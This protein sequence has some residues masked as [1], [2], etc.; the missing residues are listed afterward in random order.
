M[1]I[2]ETSSGPFSA[3]QHAVASLLVI[4]TNLDTTNLDTHRVTT[5]LDTHRIGAR[6]GKRINHA[7]LVLNRCLSRVTGP[8]EFDVLPSSADLNR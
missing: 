6:T 4:T 3:S 5:N 8:L 1:L 7:T 2:G